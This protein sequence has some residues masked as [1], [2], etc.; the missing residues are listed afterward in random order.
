MH[1]FNY[2]NAWDIATYPI[3]RFVT[4][5]GFQSYPSLESWSTATDFVEHVFIFTNFMRDRQHFSDGNLI[6][7]D[8]IEQQ[9]EL[10]QNTSKSYISALI[11][12]SQILQA[13]AVKI[14]TEHY[15]SFKGRFDESGRGNTMGALYWM[16]KDVWIAPTWSG[17]G[18][19]F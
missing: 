19:R 17:I 18:T 15:R 14:E 1:V 2:S 8:L 6:I 13:Q 5:Y 12:F 9:L 3:P 7:L 4:E 16:F 11:Y 10:P